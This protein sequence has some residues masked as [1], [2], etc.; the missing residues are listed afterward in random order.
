MS[1]LVTNE[2]YINNEWHYFVNILSLICFQE[3]QLELL[4]I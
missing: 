3:L 4:R 1:E 2:L